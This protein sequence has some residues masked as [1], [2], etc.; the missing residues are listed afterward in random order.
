TNQPESEKTDG[1]RRTREPKGKAE[2]SIKHLQ[3][4][5]KEEQTEHYKDTRKRKEKQEKKYKKEK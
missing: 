5:V 3:K 2:E 1:A 4:E